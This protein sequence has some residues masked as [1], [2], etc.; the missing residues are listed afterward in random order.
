MGLGCGSAAQVGL[1]DSGRQGLVRLRKGTG[2]RRGGG[3]D[4]VCLYDTGDMT[5][6]WVGMYQAISL[7]Q[8]ASKQ[9]QRGN[10]GVLDEEGGRAAGW[11]RRVT[12]RGGAAKADL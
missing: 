9:F 11:A 3:M 6:R 8:V 10:K 4:T 12:W 2:E 1:G 7:Q 5:N